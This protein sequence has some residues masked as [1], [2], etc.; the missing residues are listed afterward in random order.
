M[1]GNTWEIQ[2]GDCRLLMRELGDN[3]IDAVVCDPPYGI[4]F[5]DKDFDKLG[6]PQEQQEFHRSWAAEAFRVLKPGGHIVAFS[7]SR[8]YHRAAAGIED[9]GFEVRD[10]L[11]WIYGSGFPKSANHLKPAHEPIVLGRKPM[12]GVLHENLLAHDIGGL[13]ID[14]SRIPAEIG[15]WPANVI[16]QHSEGC[17]E[18]SCVEGCPVRELDEQSGVRTS[19]TGAVKRQTAKDAEGNTGSAYGAESRPA[20]TPMISYGDTGGASRYFKKFHY[21]AKASRAD[22]G[23]GN[24]HPTVKPT[25]LMHYL[26]RMVAPKGALI[27]DPFMGSGSTGLAATRN[28]YRFIGM[29]MSADYAEIARRRISPPMQSTLF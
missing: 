25:K 29:E 13:N 27:L 22:R 5:M 16:L 18:R 10:Q 11:L 17:Q 28:G 8:S 7:G 9:A 26:I 2:V 21:V 14:A 15:R 4:A 1:I 6:T 24:T 23:K 12:D 3:S 20:G 19:G